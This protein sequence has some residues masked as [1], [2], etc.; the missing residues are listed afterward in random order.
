[1]KAMTR[2]IHVTVIQTKHYKKQLHAECIKHLTLAIVYLESVFKTKI[3]KMHHSYG[4]AL[5][6]F[7]L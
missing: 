3:I 5:L 6:R 7:P 1:M 2:I 4:I